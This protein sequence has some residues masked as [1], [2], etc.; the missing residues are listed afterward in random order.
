[1]S[2]YGTSPSIRRIRHIGQKA[3]I[4]MPS[5]DQAHEMKNQ[6][7]FI[8]EYPFEITIQGVQYNYFLLWANKE[9]ISEISK[10]VKFITLKG[11]Q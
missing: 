3:C 4:I 10:S 1:L 11:E 7:A 6:A 8:L 5:D 2:P 9:H